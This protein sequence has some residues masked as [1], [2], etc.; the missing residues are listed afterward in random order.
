MFSKVSLRRSFAANLQP[1]LLVRG[2]CS[3]S[4]LSLL[5]NTGVRRLPAALPCTASPHINVL[6]QICI[7]SSPQC[8]R[9]S[10]CAGLTP[11]LL[12]QLPHARPLGSQRSRGRSS[13]LR[14]Y[15]L[16]LGSSG[17]Q[18]TCK[19]SLSVGGPVISQI[20]NLAGP[21]IRVA[22]PL[23][24]SPRWPFACSFPTIFESFQRLSC[25]LA[26]PGS[27]HSTSLTCL[28]C[29]TSIRQHTIALHSPRCRSEILGLLNWNS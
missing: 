18:S 25:A 28:R 10:G 1:T 17:A 19:W 11:Q 22:D 7:F 13:L 15:L 5:S 3:L 6:L 27:R 20:S 9:L 8:G 24:N 14:Q 21:P 23:R 16:A 12:H 29:P 26:A 4:E 2:R